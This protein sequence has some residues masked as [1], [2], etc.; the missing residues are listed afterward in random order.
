MIKE[1]MRNKLTKLV[2]RVLADE[3]LVKRLFED[4]QAVAEE[5][6]VALTSD[7]IKAIKKLPKEQRERV[8]KMAREVQAEVCLMA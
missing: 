6:G 5:V 3:K 1:E 2:G 8:E 7:E 4:P